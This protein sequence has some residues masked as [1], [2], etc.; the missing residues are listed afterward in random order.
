[1]KFTGLFAKSAAL[2]AVPA[3]LL[4]LM[5]PSAQAQT[6][7][8]IGGNSFNQPVGVA[9]DSSGNVFVADYQGGVVREIVAPAYTTV[10]TVGGAIA[11][12]VSV[13]LDSSGNLYVAALGGTNI[14]EFTVASG[15]TTKKTI[16]SGFNGTTGVA[17]DASGNVFVVDHGNNQVKEVPGQHRHAGRPGR[18]VQRPDRH[19]SRRQRQRLRRRYGQQCR[20]G[21]SGRRR[22]Q[23]DQ[24]A[25]AA[26]FSGRP[27]WRSTPAAIS[28]SPIPTMTPSRNCWP[29]AATPPSCRSAS[30]SPSRKAL[31]STARAISSSAI[32]AL[33]R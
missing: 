15:Y 2:A 31:P 9:V 6:I 18:W 1:M 12:P 23:H 11:G 29:P 28:T 22:L 16:G 24:D 10:K 3:A 21:D 7:I 30:A 25:G 27:P 26:A 4:A 8:G 20:Q 17:V 32:R 19:G 14:I 5:A 13:A 33:R